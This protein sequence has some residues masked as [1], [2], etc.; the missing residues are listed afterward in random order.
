MT[1]ELLASSH[2]LHKAL[3]DVLV[4]VPPYPGERFSVAMDA[5][6]IAFEH[7]SGVRNLAETALGSSAAALLRIQFE[8]LTRGMWILYAATETD[9]GTLRG[10]LNVETQKAANKLPML[11][12]MLKALEK[13][14]PPTAIRPLLELKEKSAGPMNSFVHSGVHSLQRQRQGFPI[15]LLDQVVRNSNGLN[16]ICGMLAAVL[17]GNAK[18]VAQ[19]KDIQSRFE[20]ALPPTSAE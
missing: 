8:A 5:T 13:V 17:S 7:A 20:S 9:I 18:C 12:E 6:E 3:L 16:T 1:R 2:L 19:V 14:G 11:A 10:P 4:G 15:L